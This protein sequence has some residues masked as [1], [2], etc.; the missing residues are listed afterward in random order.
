MTISTPRPHFE[1]VIITI[2]P[3]M[4]R[5]LTDFGVIGRAC[6]RGILK[7][8]ML[9]PRDF[10]ADTYRR[11]DERPYG[12]G[13]GMVMMAEPLYQAIQAA[14]TKLGPAVPVYF[15]SPQGSVLTQKK[16]REW[17]GSSSMILLCG[18]Y[19]GV[20]QRLIDECVDAEI[21]IGE[22]V[23]SGGELPAMI[24][25]DAITRLLPGVLNDPES[26]LQESFETEGALDY[27][28]Y[29]A[30]RIWH[31]KPVPPVLLSGDHQ[32]IKVSRL[33]RNDKEEATAL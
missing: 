5:A 21:S 14:K 32:K 9:N 15:L 10:T 1:C 19:E 2:F 8:S 11:I 22:Y 12:G 28:V 17:A 18:R 26:A 27:P 13:P 29:T 16:V 7:V 30:P 3:E 23:V 4:F 6:E 31:E 20:D 25:I 33:H 24:V